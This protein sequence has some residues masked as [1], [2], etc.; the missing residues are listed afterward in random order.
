MDKGEL[1]TLPVDL[2]CP[3][4]TS[5]SIHAGNATQVQTRII[6]AGANYPVTLEAEQML[7][8]QG[9]LCLPDFVTNCGGV[10]GGTMA[11]AGLDV[12]TIRRFVEGKVA[13]RIT[14]LIEAT[15]ERGKPLSEVAE[16]EAM[17]RFLKAK[18]RA[19]QQS[20]KNGVF[21]SGLALYRRGLVPGFT[22]RALA[23]RYFAAILQ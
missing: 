6:S 10:L 2:L 22:V 15:W 16:Q 5:E 4:A 8:R 3:C 23:P 13:P 20:F 1:L 14:A 12:G 11:F 9:T 7:L 21:Q 18:Q 19:E 17:E